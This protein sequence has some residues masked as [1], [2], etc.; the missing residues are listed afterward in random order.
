MEK[1]IQ[2]DPYGNIFPCYRFLEMNSCNVDWEYNKIESGFYD[3]CVLCN[4]KVVEY[5]N[6]KGLND[7]I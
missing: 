6:R 3:C 5:V 2:I 4:K 1:S 7:I